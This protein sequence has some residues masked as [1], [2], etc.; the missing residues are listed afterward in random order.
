MPD[1]L[2][3]IGRCHRLQS[4]HM[5]HEHRAQHLPHST[6]HPQRRHPAGFGHPLGPVP[7]D[8]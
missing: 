1:Q 4:D 3:L 7:G 6:G 5:P 2:L 8:W